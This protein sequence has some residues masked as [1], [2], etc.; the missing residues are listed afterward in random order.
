M[1]TLIMLL[2][3]LAIVG[4]I[5][6]GV[7]FLAIKDYNFKAKAEKGKVEVAGNNSDKVHK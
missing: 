1:E 7:C 4:I 3:V 6:F 5:V 2:I